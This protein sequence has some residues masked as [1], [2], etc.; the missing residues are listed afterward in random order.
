MANCL[1]AVRIKRHL[2]VPFVF[3]PSAIHEI[4]AEGLFPH[5]NSMSEKSVIPL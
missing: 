3:S 1:R 2:R 4:Q 5:E